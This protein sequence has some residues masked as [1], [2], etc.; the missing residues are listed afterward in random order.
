MVDNPANQS[1]VKLTLLIYMDG[2]TEV[3]TKNRRVLNVDYLSFGSINSQDKEIQTT[4]DRFYQDSQVNEK[5]ISVVDLVFVNSI[6]HKANSG[7]LECYKNRLPSFLLFHKEFFQVPVTHDHIARRLTHHLTEWQE[8]NHH[9]VLWFHLR[10]NHLYVLFATPAGELSITSF[11]VRKT[12]DVY[13]YILFNIQTLDSVLPDLKEVT[14]SGELLNMDKIHNFFSENV[15][16]KKLITFWQ[17][18]GLLGRPKPEISLYLPEVY[19]DRFSSLN[20]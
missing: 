14:V 5:E 10:K 6:F 9:S 13:Y 18:K 11:E 16:D 7:N 19:P 8:E 15:G 20:R 1:S 4:L 3:L 2:L 17:W 12:L